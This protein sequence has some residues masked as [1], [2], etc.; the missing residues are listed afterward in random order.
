MRADIAQLQVL[1]PY[2]FILPNGRHKLHRASIVY[3]FEQYRQ[4]T[5][6]YRTKYGLKFG[7][8]DLYW[9][10]MDL[11]GH[12]HFHLTHNWVRPSAELPGSGN[13]QPGQ[14]SIASTNLR[15]LDG[16]SMKCDV[17]LDPCRS[18]W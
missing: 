14:S 2:R 15:S 12:A 8:R 17:P 18:V 9:R 10:F 5:V 3:E 16:A 11:L 4:K 6:E 7:C 13:I 1:Q